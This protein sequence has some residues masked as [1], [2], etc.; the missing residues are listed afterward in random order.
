MK[1]QE[2]KENMWTHDGPIIYM[3]KWRLMQNDSHVS[4][5]KF[6]REIT[7]IEEYSIGLKL[8][9][10]HTCTFW[11]KGM[12]SFSFDPSF[13]LTNYVEY[14]CLHIFPYPKIHISFLEVGK[15]E[16]NT[17][18]CLGEETTHKLEWFERII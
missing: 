16:G 10:P 2:E 17:M 9:Y 6:I 14:V 5:Y 18:I 3:K 13:D 7:H 4:Q 15:K 12:T 1:V 8:F 11:S